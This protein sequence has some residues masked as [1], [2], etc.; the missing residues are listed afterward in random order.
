MEHY[1]TKS[2][3][4]ELVEAMDGLECAEEYQLDQNKV[5]NIDDRS[6]D[7]QLSQRETETSDNQFADD[8]SVLSEMPSSE[9]NVDDD[10]SNFAMDET[11]SDYILASNSTDDDK[12]NH[13][14]DDTYYDTDDDIDQENQSIR[15][16][17]MLQTPGMIPLILT[18]A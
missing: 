8:D 11:E 4:D 6:T 2:P 5:E 9:I 17:L 10:E 16:P 18:R 14:D 7:D 3:S 12:D 1:Q 13:T 15:A